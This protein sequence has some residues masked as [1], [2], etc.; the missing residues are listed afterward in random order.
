MLICALLS[1]VACSRKKREVPLRG[2][3][4]VEGQLALSTEIEKKLQVAPPNFAWVDKD[5]VRQP[6]SGVSFDNTTGRFSFEFKRDNLIRR[7]GY[8]LPELT[9]L[10]GFNRPL[11]RLS[12]QGFDQN[13]TGFIRL[14]V[15][16]EVS[17]GDSGEIFLYT[18]KLA[19]LPMSASFSTN[20]SLNMD[21]VPIQTF[22]VGSIRVNVKDSSGNPVEGALV[23]V[24]P[25][26]IFEGKADDFRPFNLRQ[27]SLFTPSGNLSD[28]KGSAHA[29]PVPL[30]ADKTAKFQIAVS[31]PNF[32]T[33]V[34][35]PAFHDPALSAVDVTLIPCESQQRNN[36]QIDWDVAFPANLFI[37]DV[38]RGSL[39][40]GTAFTNEEKVELRLINKSST[41]RGITVR[42]HEGDDTGAPVILTQEFPTFAD[43]L[44]VNLPPTFNNGTSASGRFVIN[45]IA[46]VSDEDKASGIKEFSK[47][48]DGNKGVFRLEPV[49]QTDF[50]ILGHNSAPDLISGQDDQQFKVKYTLCKAGIKIGIV[51]SEEG[52][53]EPTANL[54]PCNVNGNTFKI[55]DVFKGFSKKV[56]SNV[57]Q[58]FRTDEF[59]NVSA[60]DISAVPTL[61]RRLVEVDYGSPNAIDAE[62]GL[63]SAIVANSST[64]RPDPFA[65]APN[66]AAMT[67]SQLTP[68]NVKDFSFVFTEQS[69][70]SSCELVDSVPVADLETPDSSNGKEVGQFY[71]GPVKSRDEM[72]AAS[73]SCETGKFV[74]ST[75]SI[76]FPDNATASA[77][78]TL[79]LF[80]KAGN[81]SS[82]ELLIPPCTAP[83]N[84]ERV[85]WENP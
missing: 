35:A 61:N 26:A 46:R 54:V 28:A 50:Q 53:K 6:L 49:K 74:L 2:T 77:T 75:D 3:F 27:Q 31:H 83:D 24:I 10:M 17:T 72:L 52:K 47:T 43:K 63:L 14:E 16:S 73:V 33:Q 56:G 22:K 12:A 80:D 42:I 7:I 67:R 25:L 71:V 62:L 44:V 59:N 60:D 40:A 45:L 68:S 55:K 36:N 23:S 15:Y 51:I 79:T 30:G 1:A 9:A 76:T 4:L 18:Q 69:G 65:T 41:L 11:E 19:G 78:L 57:I 82:G 58:F 32:C 20:R 85:C 21:P 8:S 66:P 5:G 48:L 13:E 70:T 29:W 81:S 34:S 38:P 64:V 84:G 39:P 37:L